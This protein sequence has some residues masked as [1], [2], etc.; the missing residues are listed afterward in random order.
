MK[1]SAE[2]CH[3]TCSAIPVWVLACYVV[4]ATAHQG[5]LLGTRIG[6][7]IVTNTQTPKFIQLIQWAT[8]WGWGGGYHSTSVRV[9]ERRIEC[10]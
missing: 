2:V 10:R 3:V 4:R 7:N 9:R 6:G 5:R 1:H 8:R